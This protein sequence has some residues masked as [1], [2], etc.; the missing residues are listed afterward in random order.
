[1]RSRVSSDQDDL[2]WGDDV[3]SNAVL[4]TWSPRLLS[5][6]RIVA[7]LLF[8]QHGLAKLLHFPHVAMFDQLQLFSLLG[9]AGVIELVGS[10][11]L[12]IGLFTRPAAFIMSGEMAVAYFMAHGPRG[13]FPILNQGELALLFCFVFLYLAAAGGGPWSLDGALGER[14]A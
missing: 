4:A 13:F 3:I 14:A 1:M 10:V 6:L 7:A 8:L 2:A 11:L 12:L 5:V 9:L